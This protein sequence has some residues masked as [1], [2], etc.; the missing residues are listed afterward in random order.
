MKNSK[1]NVL[2]LTGGLGN[3]LFQLCYGL[4]TGES[5]LILETKK[6]NP[7]VSQKGTPD[8]LEFVLPERVSPGRFRNSV[9][10]SKVINYN[11]RIGIIPKGIE[12]SQLFREI[13]RYISRALISL[14]YKKVLKLQV[15]EG[16]GFDSKSVIQCDSTM[17]IGYFQSYK[18][19][20][21]DRIFSEME[22]LHISSPSDYFLKM[23]EEI[24]ARPTIIIHI[25]LGDYLSEDNFGISGTEYLK[26]SLAEIQSLVGEIR[27]WGF[28]DEPNKAHD[29]TLAAEIKGI[30][31]VSP[32]LLSSAETL[33]LMREGAGFVLANST[34]SWWA[35]ALRRDRSAPVIAPIPWFKDMD[36]PKDLVPPSW[37]RIKAF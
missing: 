14:H 28:S 33:Q 17:L 35:A 20:E 13:V 18:W 37:I 24:K 30:Y 3:Q 32:E 11:L 1:G 19:I 9:F 26:K 34:F 5:N 36:E 15:A 22:S 7:R 2:F 16:V 10:I 27:I 31:W 25:R 6:G 29:I 4:S 21:S 8:L 23:L 12:T